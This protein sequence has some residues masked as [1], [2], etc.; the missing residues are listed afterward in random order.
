MQAERRAANDAPPA[1]D[2]TS[3]APAQPLP[4]IDLT[5]SRAPVGASLQNLKSPLEHAKAQLVNAYQLSLSAS[6]QA[7]YSQIIQWCTAATRIELDAET[8]GFADNLS[9]WALNRRGQARADEGQGELALA[10]FNA[11]LELSPK[12]WRALHNRAVTLAQRGD[13]AESFDDLCRVIQGDPK[14]A[15]AWR[16]GTGAGRL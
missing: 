6:N 2:A 9:A 1:Y 12:N 13:F 3:G 15:K 7:E 14:F 5:A 10:D 11:A 8:R 4:A 16:H